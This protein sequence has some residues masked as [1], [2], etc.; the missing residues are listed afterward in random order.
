[1]L[2]WAEV[3]FRPLPD[4]W[5]V[6]AAGLALIAF[7]LA[8]LIN[9]AVQSLMAE[10][11]RNPQFDLI[12]P[13]GFSWRSLLLTLLFVGAIVPF[14]EELFFRGFLYG[15]LRRRMAVWP[16]AAVS[17]HFVDVRDL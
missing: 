1:M 16:A 2:A 12:A 4:G 15:W 5:L 17:G 11:P 9:L 10:P 3:G 6:R 8:S 13:V 14:A 7:V